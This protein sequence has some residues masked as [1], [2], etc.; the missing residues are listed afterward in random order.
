VKKTLTETF[1]ISTR[2]HASLDHISARYLG[3]SIPFLRHHKVMNYCHRKT[4]QFTVKMNVR[5]RLTH[6]IFR[7]PGRK[8]GVHRVQSDRAIYYVSF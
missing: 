8:N 2:F 4:N 5:L 7:S 6:N 3:Q 1:E